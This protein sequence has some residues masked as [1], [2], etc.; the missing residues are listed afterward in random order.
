MRVY[1]RCMEGK[2][3][4]VELLF[5]REVLD[6]F[7]DDLVDRLT[8]EVE[9]R[10]LHKSGDLVNS[11]AAKVTSEGI[12]PKL[13]ISFFGYGRA[14]EIK[15]HKLRKN[16]RSFNEST[17]VYLWGHKK[18]RLKSSSKKAKDTLWYSRTAYGSIN[19]L[20]SIL[21]T[22]YSEKEQERLK[23]I[24]NRQKLRLTP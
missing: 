3:N 13:E 7:G 6:E 24:L 11:L 10:E 19:R 4:D 17:E 5:I 8:E 18:K 23:N 22:N 2:Y 20:L 21:S 16:R 14:I 15:W 1:F 9:K 12:N